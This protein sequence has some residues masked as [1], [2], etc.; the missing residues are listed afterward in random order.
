[1]KKRLNVRLTFLVA[2]MMMPATTLQLF[3][4]HPIWPPPKHS[5]EYRQANMLFLRFQEALAAE[6]WEEALSLCSERVRARASEWPSPK[7]F[8]DDTVPIALLLAQDFGYW[9]LRAD[10]SA[11]SGWT[12]QAHDYGLLVPLTE[13]ESKPLLQWHWAISATNETWVVDYPP[14]K[15]EQ[16][17]AGKK[18][19]I[20]EREDKIKQIRQSLEPGVR[21]MRTRLSAVNQPF[22]IGSPML[23]RVEF[24]NLGETPVHYVDSGVAFAPLKLLDDKNQ[25]P[26][27]VEPPPLQIMQHRGQAAPGESVVL[28]E[29]IDLNRQYTI[30]KPGTYSVQFTGADLAIGE[31]VSHEDW[32]LFAENEMAS[33]NDFV[34][35]TNKFPSNVINVEVTFGEK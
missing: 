8:F 26:T 27:A 14:V 30:T 34:A 13:P 15:L 31:P 16:Y 7:A 2:A 17:I 1:M 3:G 35:A 28:A 9:T 24:T 18:A 20:Q 29:K 10:R 5:A 12:E 33:I 23:F 32:G 6:R 25:P 19:A 21:G 4:G 11:A 22:R